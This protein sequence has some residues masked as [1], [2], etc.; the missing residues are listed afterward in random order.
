MVVLGLGNELPRPPA[1]C[2]VPLCRRGRTPLG[3]AAEAGDTALCRHLVGA[4][5][6]LL[7]ADNHGR[8][9]RRLAYLANQRDTAEVRAR[10]AGPR[11]GCAGCRLREGLGD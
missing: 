2:A 7:A 5:A 6:S 9:P 11:P 4:G 1:H 10:G 3:V 8:V